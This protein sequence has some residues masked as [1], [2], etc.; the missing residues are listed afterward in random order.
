MKKVLGITGGTGSGK[1]TVS[2]ILKEKG[3]KI[4][5]A[6]L[7]ARKI[8]MPSMPALAE[9]KEAFGEE[10][11]LP[12][13]TMDRK[14]V[15][16]IVFSDSEKL[17]ILN[18]IT[19]KYIIAEIKSFLSEN[20]GVLGIDAALLFQTELYL[21]CDKTLCVLAPQSLRQ[22]RIEIRDNLSS[23][24]AINRISSQESED[25]YRQR[26]DYILENDGSLEDLK[27][28]IEEIICKEIM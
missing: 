14:K 25:Y 10:V 21:L 23:E 13:G 27:K 12:D 8:V 2:Q 26:A 7:V 22:K 6:D 28:K 20:D 19:H 18:N 4:I 3:V 11:I 15:G 9:I 16:E 17:S 5:D 1:G 24:L